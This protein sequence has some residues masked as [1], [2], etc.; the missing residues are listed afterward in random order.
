MY[1]V[2]ALVMLSLGII[3]TAG[4][5]GAA[6]PAVSQAAQ[7]PQPATKLEGFRPAAGTLL[8]LGY[9]DL[10]RVG[11]IAVEVRGLR[12]SKGAEAKGLLVEVAEGQYSKERAFVDADEIEELLRGIDALLAVKTNPTAF[13]YFEVKY[14][15]RG[16]LQLS[17]FNDKRNGISYS[18]R[19]G[20][21]SHAQAFIDEGDMTNLRSMF[22]AAQT[23]LSPAVASDGNKAPGR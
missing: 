19:A 15:T 2:L 17:A 12:D 21:I 11:A 22:V 14:T 16:S 13:E 18:V 10:G 4:Q 9:D 3:V 5:S 20:A 6:P 8:T 1:R 7:S 23:R